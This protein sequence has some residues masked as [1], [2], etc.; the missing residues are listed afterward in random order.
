MPG[1]SY[2]GPLHPTE[3]KDCKHCTSVSMGRCL[4]M[5][6]ER[7]AGCPLC[8]A[9]AIG[10][11][12]SHGTGAVMALDG[13]MSGMSDETRARFAPVR[14]LID[15]RLAEMPADAVVDIKYNEF[16][17]DIPEPHGAC[18]VHVER[19]RGMAHWQMAI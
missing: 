5:H 19:R 15:H 1:W 9:V 13:F 18:S 4:S 7:Q 10:R 11:C 14:A 8:N 3:V 17:D 2:S 12:E 16:T 6:G